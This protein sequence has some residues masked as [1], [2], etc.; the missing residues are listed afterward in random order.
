[1]RFIHFR[2]PLGLHNV[3][4]R[5]MPVTQ[6]ARA[7]RMIRF[8]TPYGSPGM[9]TSLDFLVRRD[10][11]REHKCVPGVVN[12]DTPLAPGEV[13]ITVDAFAFTSNNVTY[14]T[15]G[16][17]LDYWKFFPAVEPGWGRIPVWGFGTV[18]RSACDGIARRERF[19][20]Y[21]PMS[22][23]VVL[24][25]VK[26]NA[27]GFSDGTPHRAALHPVYNQ[28]LRTTA[29]P[30]YDAAREEQL[31]LLRP[32]FVLSFLVDDFLADNGFFG[33]RAVVLSSASSKT[34]YGIAYRLASRRTVQV[35]GLTSY[36]NLEFVKRLGC[37]DHVLPY[38]AVDR[39]HSEPTVYVDI[40]GSADV[41]RAV[42]ERLGDQLMY[43]CAV[44]G[45][46]WEDLAGAPGESEEA[47][48]PGP[49]PQFFFAPAQM[50]KRTADWGAADLQQRIVQA[51][52]D[53]M[54]PVTSPTQPWLRVV[55]ARGPEAV[56]RVVDDMLAGH[57]RPEEGWVLTL[58]QK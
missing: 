6:V 20:G 53:F 55:H 22:T 7:R 13:L 32:L 54:R 45:T 52:R 8:L 11:P 50:K 19:F 43:S 18:L 3:R 23:H 56:A 5:Q 47:H 42:H 34:A 35:I 51:W 31:M 58:V 49:R 36:G 39:L 48:L 33:A 1:M 25:P 41:R 24:Q 14:A 38:G 29:D 21:F 28:Y 12:D 4:T 37:Y 9:P 10:N 40:A 27:A 44:G 15:W 17:A 57:V 26:L 2:M 16:E 46:H 30:L